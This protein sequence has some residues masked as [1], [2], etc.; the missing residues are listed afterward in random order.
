MGSAP[1]CSV[2]H[3][4]FSH[5]EAGDESATANMANDVKRMRTDNP[6]TKVISAP[7]LAISA[8]AKA[9][10]RIF[11]Y[12][13]GWDRVIYS[14]DGDLLFVSTLHC[15]NSAQCVPFD[16][17]LDTFVKSLDYTGNVKVIDKRKHH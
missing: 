1:T 4:S 11:E 2:H 10:V 13:H 15:I 7:E 6:Q 17:I 3:F 14:E 9:S 8:G 12:Q 16:P 5:K